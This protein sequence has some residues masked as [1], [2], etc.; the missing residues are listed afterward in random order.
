[1]VKAI[2][3]RE[4]TPH[5]WAQ[6]MLNPPREDKIEERIRGYDELIR[7]YD[8][9]IREYDEVLGDVE[10]EPVVI[11]KQEVAHGYRESAL[12]EI[13]LPPAVASPWWRRLLDRLR[14]WL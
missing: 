2:N 9:R 14:S 13:M 10:L 12:T 1:M 7:G 4:A 3:V 8:D 6:A 11:D 5:A